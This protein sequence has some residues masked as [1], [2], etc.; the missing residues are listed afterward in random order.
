MPLEDSVSVWGKKWKIV[1]EEVEKR[2]FSIFLCEKAT[3]L[4]TTQRPLSS[5]ISETR[6]CILFVQTQVCQDQ[7][8][9]LLS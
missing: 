8:V 9:T 6:S 4:T 3:E 1:G 7:N 2:H 5:G